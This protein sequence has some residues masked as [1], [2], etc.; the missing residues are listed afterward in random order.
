MA[1]KTSFEVDFSPDTESGQ[2]L[3]VG[4]AAPGVGGLTAV[5]YLVR[6]MA[7]EQIGHVTPDALPAITPVEAGRPRNHTRLYNLVDVDLTVL[8]GELFVPTWAA[9]SFVETLLDWVEGVDVEE[10][11]V[12]HAVPYPHE[13]SEHAVFYVATD[14]YRETTL[15]ETAIEPLQGGVLDGIAGE[16]MSRSLAGTAPPVGVYI[17]PVHPPG[18]DIDAS[19]YLL[20]AL[21]SVYGVSLDLTE[22]EDLSDEIH[23]YYA[24]LSERLAALEDADES[25]DSREFAYDRM[26]M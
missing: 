26:Y 3:V 11:A 1:P 10:I 5:D 18:P 15:E 23:Q 24:T 16:L 2:A 9:R 14:E 7:V 25:A 19:L 21:E 12:L 13:H 8:V 20:D 6:Q 4:L 17:T 22:L